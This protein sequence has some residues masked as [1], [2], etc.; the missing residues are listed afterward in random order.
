VLS[1][2]EKQELR[3]MAGSESLREEFRVLRRNSRAIER[4]IGVDALAHWLTVIGRVCPG[5]TKPR[6]FV[7]YPHVRI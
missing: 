6:P 3:E 5:A 7:H 1:D 2:E 4:E